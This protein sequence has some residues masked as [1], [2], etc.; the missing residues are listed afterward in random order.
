MSSL[1]VFVHVSLKP[2]GCRCELWGSNFWRWFCEGQ[3]AACSN[4]YSSIRSLGSRVALECTSWT[5]LWTS[6]CSR[7]NPDPDFQKILPM[8]AHHIA[9]HPICVGER[10]SKRNLEAASW[11]WQREF[12]EINYLDLEFYGIVFFLFFWSL[13][14]FVFWELQNWLPCEAAKLTQSWTRVPSDDAARGRFVKPF[15]FSKLVCHFVLE[16]S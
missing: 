15:G 5:G 14:C 2:A 7:T 13:F 8:V 3:S 9:W 11:T 12:I 16:G 4:V 10:E 6:N 1:G